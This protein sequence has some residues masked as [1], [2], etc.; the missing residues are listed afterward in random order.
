MLWR[1]NLCPYAEVPVRRGLPI[2]GPFAP[3][4]PVSHGHRCEDG[5]LS[6]ETTGSC[7]RT[8]CP[9][10]VDPASKHLRADS[11]PELSST[12]FYGG[13]QALLSLCLAVPL[14]VA[15]QYTPR[16]MAANLN[17]MTACGRVPSLSSC[18]LCAAFG[19]RR[20]VG[21]GMRSLDA[22][23]FPARGPLPDWIQS[24]RP[25]RP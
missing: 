6:A 2:S 4:T 10:Q 21:K 18:P 12:F 9:F 7:V 16:A 11:F 17:M 15:P 20:A 5:T 23:T 3:L 13:N 1:C 24:Q 25:R 19:G 22:R 14:A 8:T